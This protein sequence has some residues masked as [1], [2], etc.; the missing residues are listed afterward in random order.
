MTPRKSCNL[1]FVESRSQD[2]PNFSS[3]KKDTYRPVAATKVD[4]SIFP[5]LSDNFFCL[6]RKNFP[7]PRDLFSLSVGKS[8]PLGADFFWPWV[9]HWTPVNLGPSC[10]L[11]PKAHLGSTDQSRLVTQKENDLRPKEIGAERSTEREK[12]YDP[13]KNFHRQV[14]GK[15]SKVFEILPS[16]MNLSWV[17]FQDGQ[18]SLDL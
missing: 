5:D 16:T 7:S 9:R 12:S 2:Q 14:S 17:H 8:R 3:T 10:L 13:E 6:G 18:K 4:P 15:I 11:G 1:N